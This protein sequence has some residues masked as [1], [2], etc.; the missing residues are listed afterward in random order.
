MCGLGFVMPWVMAVL[1]WDNTLEW[2]GKNG[3]IL[4]S[5]QDAEANCRVLWDTN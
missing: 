1:I 3:V 5:S 4:L 2:D